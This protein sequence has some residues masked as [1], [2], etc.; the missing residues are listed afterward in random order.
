[1]KLVSI[2]DKVAEFYSN[3][4]TFRTEQE[5]VRS[6]TEAIQ[7][8]DSPYSK[9]PTDYD[10]VLVGEWNAETG[11]IDGINRLIIVGKLLSNKDTN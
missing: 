3:P 6:F 4:L 8:A 2:Y 5:A 10:L 11:E 1:M 9:N 7:G